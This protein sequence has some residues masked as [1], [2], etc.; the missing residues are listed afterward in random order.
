MGSEMCIRD[1]VSSTRIRERLASG[2]MAGASRLLGRP[3]SMYGRVVRGQALGRTLGFP[4]ANI[5]L[6]RKATPINGIF[7]VRASGAG[8]T[9]QPA[10]ASIGTRPTVGGKETLLEVHLFDFS[11][12]LYGRHLDITFVAKLRD[13]EKFDDLDAMTVQMNEDAR[14]AR[15]LLA[16]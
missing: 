15:K 2:N 6:H 3:F 13:E 7:A 9:Q 4:T 8:L 16:A 14:Q 11:G 12:D 5:R 10:V 1:R